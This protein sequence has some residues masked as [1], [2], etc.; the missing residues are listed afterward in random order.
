M[1][2]EHGCATMD[3]GYELTASIAS[4][5]HKSDDATNDRKSNPWGNLAD[6]KI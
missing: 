2:K 6:S 4:D 5:C 1:D 3:A